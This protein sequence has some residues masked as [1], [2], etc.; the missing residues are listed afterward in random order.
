MRRLL[1]LILLAACVDPAEPLDVGPDAGAEAAAPE[2]GAIALARQ[3]PP[4]ARGLPPIDFDSDGRL[5]LVRHLYKGGNTWA[6]RIDLAANGFGSVDV[7]FQGNYGDTFLLGHQPIPV[8]GDYDRDDIVDIAYYTWD[9]FWVIDRAN[10]GF[11]AFDNFPGIDSGVSAHGDPI[12]ADYNHDGDLD[13]AVLG[14]DGTWRID[15]FEAADDDNINFGFAGWDLELYGYGTGG[16]YPVVADFDADTWLDIA[17]RQDDGTWRIDRANPNVPASPFGGFDMQLNDFGG[18]APGVFATA[19]DFDGDARA[20]LALRNPNGVWLFDLSRNNY[21]SFDISSWGWGGGDTQPLPGDYDNDQ[22]ADLAA[23]DDCGAW[24]IDYTTLDT[25][26]RPV[27]AGADVTATWANPVGTQTVTTRDGLLA[28]LRSDFPATIFVQGAIDIGA[29][30]FLP[31]PACSRLTSNRDRLVPGGQIFTT[32]PTPEQVFEVLGDHVRIDHLRFRGPG[33][34]SDVNGIHIESARDVRI[35]H[36]E[37]SLFNGAAVYADDRLHR[38]TRSDGAG[39]LHVEDSFFHH[40]QRQDEGYGVDIGRGA[41]AFIERNTFNW[42][43]HGITSDGEP[44]TGYSAYRNLFLEGVTMFDNDAVAHIDVHGTGG[45]SSGHGG[46]AG[47]YFDIGQNYVRGNQ[48]IVNLPGGFA[49]RPAI[50]LR[51]TPTDWLVAHDNVFE[52]GEYNTLLPCWWA[53]PW[54]NPFGWFDCTDRFSKYGN[55]YDRDSTA[56]L[57]VGDFDGDQRADVFMGTGISWWY[58]SG[59]QT[60]WRFLRETVETASELYFANVDS[61]PKTDV[62]YHKSDGVLVYSSGG[63]G[64]WT[65]L[66]TTPASPLP[67]LHF[68][69]FDGDTITDIFRTTG[70]QWWIW[71]G[72]VKVWFPHVESSLSFA[73]MRFGQFDGA[74]GTDVL[75]YLSGAWKVNRSGSAGAWQTL[76]TTSTSLSG[77]I[78]VDVNNDG[79]TDLVKNGPF[80]AATWLVSMS[81]AG[82][83]VQLRG[84]N[85]TYRDIG[86]FRFGNFDGGTQQH[87]LRTQPS[88]PYRFVVSHGFTEIPHE[89]S[90]IDMR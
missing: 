15:F 11:G 33:G 20:D 62:L 8:P 32:D 75:A 89:V 12:P 52:H 56:D 70:S 74:A 82:P 31:I 26:N 72:N 79:R 71:H 47:E 6:W 3:R 66:T 51:G 67:K 14:D 9:G 61:D 49:Q 69:D 63:T 24:R 81:A 28:A 85:A 77:T 60:E 54:W 90:S 59:G 10:N 53:G 46:T 4:H 27:W 1:P 37:A 50:N 58:S 44:E 73:N 41:W 76:F 48:E 78:A 21:G 25:S 22:I 45:G 68:A 35:D 55:K 5:D 7:A 36:I 42:N 87:A 86:S 57:A 34:S 39:H 84:G 80:S 65:T 83:F 30:R 40:N 43:R 17:V 16:A 64:P 29:E 38:I 18:N 88:A 23:K 2:V 19:A 13:L